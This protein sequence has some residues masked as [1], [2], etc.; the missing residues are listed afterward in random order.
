MRT[1]VTKSVY[2]CNEL[3]IIENIWQQQKSLRPD[4]CPS[5]EGKNKFCSK[6]NIACL[7]VILSQYYKI[8]QKR[9]N[10]AINF[11]QN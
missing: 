10:N 7:D 6:P 9:N 3:Q 5:R 11:N 4:M 2:V 8:K 1:K